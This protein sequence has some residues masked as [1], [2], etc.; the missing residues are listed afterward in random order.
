MGVARVCSLEW[1]IY[2]MLLLERC[3][4]VLCPWDGPY[5]IIPLELGKM[6]HCSAYWVGP[7]NDVGKM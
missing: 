6:S 5:I 1:A 2:I 3:N 4:V 7:Y